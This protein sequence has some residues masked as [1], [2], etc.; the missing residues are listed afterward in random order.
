MFVE[1]NYSYI[2]LKLA[3][4]PQSMYKVLKSDTKVDT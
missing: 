4:S 1:A 2:M 3:L